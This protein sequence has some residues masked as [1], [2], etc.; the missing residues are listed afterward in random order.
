VKGAIFDLDG[1]LAN[2]EEIHKKAWEIA[3][4]RLGFETNIDISTLL[5]RKTIDIAKILVGEELA[6]TLAKIK[7]Q[8]Y[9]ELIKSL[10]K[11]K[12]CANELINY[13]KSKGI[14]IAVVTS[15][16]RTSALEVLKIINIHPDVLIAGDDVSIGK[17]DPTPI[18]EAIRKLRVTP[19][20]TIGVGDT[21][22]D[23]VAYYKSGIRKIFV[24]KSSV[25]LDE[26]EVYKY[27]A[28]ILSSLCELLSYNN[29]I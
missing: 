11:S 12:E 4:N 13:L 26:E 14:S 3:L 18:L 23:V 19:T 10:A 20:E 16:M 25:P 2:T 9:S 17:P 5:G 21:L 6:E 24:V 29:V 28:Q 1:T 15:S 8:I 7:T 27:G 22:Y